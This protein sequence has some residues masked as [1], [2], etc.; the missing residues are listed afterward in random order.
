MVAVVPVV[1]VVAVAVLSSASL[2]TR[3]LAFFA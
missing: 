2:F 1:P 3:T